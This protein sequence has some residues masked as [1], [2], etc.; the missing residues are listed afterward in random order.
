MAEMKFEGIEY[1]QRM[2]ELEKLEYPKPN[3][4]SS[5]PRSTRFRQTS[6]GR[7]GKHPPEIHRA[8]CSNPSARSPITSA[9]V[10]CSAR[11]FCCGT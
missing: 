3:R 1:D 7:S 11:G 9:T 2:A 6:V 5:Y 8:R 4:S 10:S